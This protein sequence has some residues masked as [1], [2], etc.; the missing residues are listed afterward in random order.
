MYLFLECRFEF[1]I[2][3]HKVILLES[4][5]ADLSCLQEDLSDGSHLYTLW[6]NRPT[7]YMV[8]CFWPLIIMT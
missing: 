3:E 4:F 2:S 1:Y 6:G 5:R 8:H 7:W